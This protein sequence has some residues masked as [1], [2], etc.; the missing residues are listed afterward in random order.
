MT[1]RLTPDLLE[2]SYDRLCHTAPFDR[3]NL[4]AGEDV[5][6]KVTRS[7]TARGDYYWCPKRDRHVIRISARCIGTLANLDETMAHE[8][9]HLHQKA[10]GTETSAQHNAAFRKFADRVCRAHKFDPKAF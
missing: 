9:I 6:F 5:D 3:W 8:M 4:P 10:S 7:D 2:L 1:I